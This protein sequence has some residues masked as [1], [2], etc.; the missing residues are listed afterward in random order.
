MSNNDDLIKIFKEEAEDLLDK[1]HIS[2]K[3]WSSVPTDKESLQAILRDTHTLKGSARMVGLRAINDYIQTLENFFQNV[4]K[5]IIPVSEEIMRELQYGIDF[6]VAYIHSYRDGIFTE[7]IAAPYERIKK[8]ITDSASEPSQEIKKESAT[9]AQSLVLPK[10]TEYVRVAL[11]ALEKVSDAIEE[12]NILRSRITDHIHRVLSEANEISKQFFFLREQVK[13]LQMKSDVN[14]LSLQSN[15]VIEKEEG[16]DVLEMDIYSQFQKMTRLILENINSIGSKIEKCENGIRNSELNLMQQ[17]Q[18]VKGVQ[19]KL[20]HFRLVSLSY[21]VPRLERLVRQVAHELEKDVTFKVEKIQ[22]EVD[23]KI[24]EKLTPVVEHL[25]RNAIDHGIDTKEDRMRQGKPPQ[26]N[27]TFSIY[28]KGSELI[29]KLSDDGKGIEVD[30]VRKTAIKKGIWPVDKSMTLEEAMQLIFVSGFSTKKNVTP[31]SGQGVGL[32][33]VNTEINKLGGVIKIDSRPGEG[34][35]FL[36]RLPM[37]LALNHILIFTMKQQCFAFP[38]PHLLAIKRFSSNKIYQM[39]KDNMTIEYNSASYAVV[40][41]GDLIG[42]GSFDNRYKGSKTLPVI[43]LKSEDNHTAVIVDRL[44]GN[45]SVAV[46]PL[47][48]QMQMMKEILGTSIF[49]DEKI[50]LILDPSEIIQR[51]KRVSGANFIDMSTESVSP[52]ILIV[53]DS[54]TVREV[55]T[56]LLQRHRYQTVSVRDGKEALSYMMTELPDVV[57]LDLEMPEMDGFSVLKKMQ[58]D[59]R[60]KEIPVILITSRA[61]EKHRNH[62][63][64]MNVSGYFVKPY[65]EEHLLSAIRD[66]INAR[67]K[68]H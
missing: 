63:K 67:R 62:A 50:V 1:I 55:T 66:I 42:I 49:E 41:L 45:W 9:E 60:L 21:I 32:D 5:N 56:R 65:I 48:R 47:N 27:I 33:V 14:L 37:K 3:Q 16:F 25:I 19:E 36:I 22:G 52:R 2:F 13:F 58:Q 68:K 44:I 43:L 30:S 10:P 6:L 24:L 23:K 12:V 59:I 26:G 53:D 7:N 40:Y 46:K 17:K 11:E 64:S 8:Y 38:I 51:A 39:L 54:V 29:L 31:I 18:I 28:K 57:L 4:N 15:I 61:G 20:L 34:V 35:G